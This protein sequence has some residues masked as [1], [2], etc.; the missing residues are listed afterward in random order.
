MV[1][2]SGELQPTISR[3]AMAGPLGPET[4][5]ISGK[6]G[7]RGLRAGVGAVKQGLGAFDCVPG[8]PEGEGVGQSDGLVALVDGPVALAFCLGELAA[9]FGDLLWRAGGSFECC[10]LRAEHVDVVA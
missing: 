2:V 8:P 5:G 6:G 9:G 10:E 3:P 1:W 7:T 4:A